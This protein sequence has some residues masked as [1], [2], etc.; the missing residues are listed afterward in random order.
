MKKFFTHPATIT[1]LIIIGIGS[2]LLIGK[3]YW[4][5]FS[6][7]DQAGSNGNASSSAPNFKGMTKDSLID[8]LIKNGGLDRAQLQNST[9]EQLAVMANNMYNANHSGSGNRNNS[10][11]HRD[12]CYEIKIIN[13]VT[14]KL[15]GISDTGKMHDY[16]AVYTAW[17]TQTQTQIPNIPPQYAI[18]TKQQYDNYRDKCFPLVP[19]AVDNKCITSDGRDGTI[20]N[21]IC[22]DNGG[23]KPTQGERGL[24]K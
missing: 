10:I 20:V 24:K 4:G 23:A 19:I 21:G 18:I 12:T 2:I 3:K 16:K 11:S 22:Y 9:Q 15:T 1:I 17:N 7:N 5:W 14:Y 8:W 13:G 6:S